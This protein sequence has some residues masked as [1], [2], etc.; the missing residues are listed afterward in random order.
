[1]IIKLALSVGISIYVHKNERIILITGV[2]QNRERKSQYSL[3]SFF[4]L[5]TEF[6]SRLGKDFFKLLSRMKLIEIMVIYTNAK[7]NC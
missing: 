2:R 7:K 4:F 6:L 3:F 5:L 1:M